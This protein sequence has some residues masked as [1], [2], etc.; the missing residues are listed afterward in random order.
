MRPCLMI[1]PSALHW[2]WVVSL[3]INFKSTKTQVISQLSFYLFFP[4]MLSSFT[5]SLTKKRIKVWRFLLTAG[6]ILHS[7]MKNRITGVMNACCVV[8]MGAFVR[9]IATT[10]LTYCTYGDFW[11]VNIVIDFCFCKRGVLQLLF[12]RRRYF[13]FQGCLKNNRKFLQ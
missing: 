10:I 13:R 12:E 5:S 11:W 2:F 8:C 7:L 1:I 6:P 9:Y 4:N 3:Y